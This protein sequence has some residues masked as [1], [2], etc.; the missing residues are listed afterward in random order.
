MYPEMTIEQ[1]QSLDASKRI[2]Y[3]DLRSEG[4]YESSTIP[5]SLNLPLLN[6]KEREVVGTLYVQKDVEMAKSQGVSFV[7]QK[8]PDL[9]KNI[10]THTRNY[11]HVVLFCERGGFRSQ[12]L[13]VLLKS[14]HIN[15]WK[16][17]GG[18]KAYRAFINKQLP[19]IF[20]ELMPIVLS[21]NTGCG[22]T[23]L[24]QELRRKGMD[25][26]DLE[27]CAN[28][29]GSL[30]GSVGLGATNSQKTFESLVYDE[31]KTRKTNYVFME[32]ESRRI[33]SVILPPY[34]YK[35]IQNA[36]AI[37]ITS[38]L[39]SRVERI[40][41]EY[42]GDTDNDIVEALEKLRKYLSNERV[43]RFIQEVRK[44]NYPPVIRE[45]IESYYDH[46]YTKGD[47]T[48]VSEFDHV[49]TEKTAEQILMWKQS[50]YPQEE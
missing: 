35:S 4:E 23:Q 8:L 9:Y 32:A 42:T 20:E 13:F 15:V 17:H 12:S 1:L 30:L 33:G 26:L 7:S 31:L 19:Q 37:N 45:L 24:L 29:R 25:V 28:H 22:K 27:A 3:I 11:D 48:I 44:N 46:K 21:G 2:L 40:L 36:V 50:Y 47:Y 39:E 10:T 34:M 14:L 43:D 41:K 18:Y 5:G 16:L 49:D 6:N 38:P